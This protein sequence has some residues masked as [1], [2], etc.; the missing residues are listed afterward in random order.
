MKTI[1]L[2]NGKEIELNQAFNMDCLEFMKMLPDKCIDLVLTDPPYGV[3]QGGGTNKTRGKLATSQDYKDYND[4]HPLSKEHFQEMIRVSR[5]QI[6]FG[7]NHY[8]SLIPFDSS[9]WL[10]WDKLNGETDF[11]DCELAWTSHKTAVRKY[12]FRWQGMLQGNMKNKEK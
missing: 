6:F 7:A 9:S 8:I 11:A 5:H 2:T 12:E 1:T 3:N 4:K 10:V